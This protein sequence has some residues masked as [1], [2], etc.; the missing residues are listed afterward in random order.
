MPEL[1]NGPIV[2]QWTASSSTPNG[3]TTPSTPGLGGPGLGGRKGRWGLGEAMKGLCIIN[4]GKGRCRYYEGA[5]EM[6]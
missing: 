1:S 4:Q 2:D 5:M 6:L 3:M